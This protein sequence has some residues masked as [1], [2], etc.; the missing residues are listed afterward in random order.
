MDDF[1]QSFN[2]YFQYVGTLLAVVYFAD[3]VVAYKHYRDF[4]D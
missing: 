4:N 1:K 3:T 2:I